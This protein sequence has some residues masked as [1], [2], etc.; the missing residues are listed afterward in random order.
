MSME[1]PEL[2]RE[3]IRQVHDHETFIAWVNDKDAEMFE[4]WWNEKGFAAFA[5]WA[6]K[7]S[8]DFME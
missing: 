7:N 2:R 3:I 5:K 6:E 1:L 4:V 8:G